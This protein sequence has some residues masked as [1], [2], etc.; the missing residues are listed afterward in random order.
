MTEEEAIQALLDALRD[1]SRN[2]L[3]SRG[4]VLRLSKNGHVWD[5]SGFMVDMERWLL[6]IKAEEPDA[7]VE[8]D[9]ASTKEEYEWRTG[10][11][12]SE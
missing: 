5:Y 12:W 1:P 2:V 9:V 10:E 6:K 3:R 7:V 4:L 8:I 11:R